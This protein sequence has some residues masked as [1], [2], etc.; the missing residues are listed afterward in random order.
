MIRVA[1]PLAPVLLQVESAARPRAMRPIGA[2]GSRVRA[3]LTGSV[4]GSLRRRLRLR[5][6]FLI[7]DRSLSLHCRVFG[8][9]AGRP[10][11]RVAPL[12]MTELVGVPRLTES[13]PGQC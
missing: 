13:G 11:S 10:P 1:G 3:R 5:R 6:Q 7:Y 9:R 2:A 4:S 12:P 8:P